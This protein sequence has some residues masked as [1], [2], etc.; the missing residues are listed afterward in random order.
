MKEAADDG[1]NMLLRNIGGLLLDYTA[2][3]PRRQ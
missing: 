2:L 1:G 3:Y